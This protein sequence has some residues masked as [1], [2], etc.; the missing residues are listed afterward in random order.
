MCRFVRYAALAALPLVPM[1]LAAQDTGSAPAV[2]AGVTSGVLRFGDGR[3]QQGVS[4]V[5]RYHL[6]PG[7]SVA[8]TPAFAR[9]SAPASLGGGSVSGLT[10]MPVELALDHA[11]AVPASPTVGLG[12]AVS[13][14]IGDRNAGFGSGALGYSV[15][16]GI[17]ASPLERLSVHVGAGRPLSDFTTQSALGGSGSTWGEAEA[18]YDASTHLSATLGLDGDLSSRD[19]LGPARAIAAGLTMNLGGPV[20]LVIDGAHGLSGAAA[21]WTF[22]VALGTD[23]AGIESL[24]SSSPLRRFMKSLGGQSYQHGYA[25][26]YRGRGR[27]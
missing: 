5:L 23:F 20:S 13:L 19:S 25:A 1:A 2:T 14:P 26:V 21:R 24:G 12:L 16:G 4:G 22:S 11:I 7:M 15:E 10:D 6:L 18:S 9:V 27:P 8:A 17:G 3:T